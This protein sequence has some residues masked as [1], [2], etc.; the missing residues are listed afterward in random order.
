MA[1]SPTAQDEPVKLED[2]VRDREGFA[3][4]FWGASKMA[5]G[6]VVALLLLMAIFLL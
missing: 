3:A 1:Q 4:G 6:G 2:F 5:I